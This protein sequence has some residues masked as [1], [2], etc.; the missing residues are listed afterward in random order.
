MS[1]STLSYLF[2]ILSHI[3]ISLIF[4]NIQL[5][6]KNCPIICLFSLRVQC[7]SISFPVSA[8]F[9]GYSLLFSLKWVKLVLVVQHYQ[10]IFHLLPLL[11]F[12]QLSYPVRSFR[13]FVDEFRSFDCGEFLLLLLAVKNLV[14]QFLHNLRFRFAFIL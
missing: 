1:I 6:F 11:F 14:F 9:F 10:I 5:S 8:H 12:L 4:Q 2:P 7:S 3:M 13:N